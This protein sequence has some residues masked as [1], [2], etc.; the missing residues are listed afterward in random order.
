MSDWTTNYED[1]TGMQLTGEELETLV[2]AGGE[3]V[4]NWTN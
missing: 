2:S 3:C 1:L 4:L